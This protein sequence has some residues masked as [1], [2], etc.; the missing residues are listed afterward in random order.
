M[1]PYKS[2]YD[3]TVL[4]GEESITYPGDASFSREIIE[5]IEDEGNC[6]LSNLI[7]SSHSGTH[8]DAPSHFVRGGRSI[9]KYTAADFIFPA[10]VVEITNRVILPEELKDVQIDAGDALLFKTKNSTLGLCRNGVFS[11]D[12]VYLSEEAVDFCVEKSVGLVGVDYISI[13]KYNDSI[14]ANHRKIL[15]NNILILEGINLE[16]VLPGRFTLFCPALKIKKGEASPV[17]A[18]LMKPKSCN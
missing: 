8:I 18:F 2:V 12:Y 5:N 9:D 11:K 13:D 1:N 4:L 3:I 10:R 17:R 14:F 15:G 16:G 7:M 6:E